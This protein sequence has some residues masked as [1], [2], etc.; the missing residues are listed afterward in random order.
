MLSFV[1]KIIN[2]CSHF[3][4]FKMGVLIAFLM[5]GIVFTIN[6]VA[7]HQTFASLTAFGKQW[8]YSFLFGGAVLKSS[9]RITNAF[10]SKMLAVT[11]ATLIPSIV[12]LLLVYGIHSL[13]GTP[14]P[15]ES[16]LPTLLVIPGAL[17]WAL[18]KRKNKN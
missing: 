11:L 16:T 9:E 15:F 10:K 6:Y 1:K 4:D 5:G 2:Y 3:I 17:Y 8:V 14:R 7:T 18:R 13:K 12:S